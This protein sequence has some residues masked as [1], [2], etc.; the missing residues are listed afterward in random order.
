MF[1]MPMFRIPNFRINVQSSELLPKVQNN[2]LLNFAKVKN[3]WKN[4]RIIAQSA[5]WESA[6]FQSSEC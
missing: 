3:M 6:E 4:F 1:R 2:S 5:E